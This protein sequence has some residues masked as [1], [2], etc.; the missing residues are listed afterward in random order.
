MPRFALA[1][2]LLVTLFAARPA[3]AGGEAHWET[4][5]DKAVA[6]AKKRN[7]IVM[8]LFTGSDW[9]PPCKAFEASTLSKP[10]FAAYAQEN[11]VLAKFDIPHG[12]FVS[13]QQKAYNQGLMG[14]YGVRG[15]PTVILFGPDGAEITRQVGGQSMADLKR[16]CDGAISAKSLAPKGEA[17][18]DEPAVRVWTDNRGR[19]VRASLVRVKPYSIIMRTPDGKEYDVPKNQLSAEDLAYVKKHN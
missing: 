6:L 10:D 15:V 5:L 13:D 7:T 3:A 12:N 1:A 17:G 19:T 11:L 8:A 18:A 14:K 9:C 2:I 4:D 16:F